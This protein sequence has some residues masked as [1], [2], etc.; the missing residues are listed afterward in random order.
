MALNLKAPIHHSCSLAPSPQQPH[1][2]SSKPSSVSFP[3]S[4]SLP[5]FTSLHVLAFDF[6]GQGF[7][8]WLVSLN[9]RLCN[10]KPGSFWEEGAFIG[11]WNGSCETID[12][13]VDQKWRATLCCGGVLKKF[14]T[15]CQDL[16]FV[17][18]LYCLMVALI[19]IVFA[20]WIFEVVARFNEIVTKSLL[21]GALETFRKYSVKEEDI[22]VC[23]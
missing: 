21:E 16:F 11:C 18:C 13:I 2:F 14:D 20:F 22:D 1:V 5:G 6:L 19:W 10:W 4:P 8:H 9:F 3:H 15:C 23:S 7:F 17:F 12:W